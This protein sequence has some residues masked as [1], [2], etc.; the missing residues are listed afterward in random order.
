MVRV[1]RLEITQSS[2][3]A[4]RHADADGVASSEGMLILN[5]GAADE[6]LARTLLRERRLN[7]LTQLLSSAQDISDVLADIVR[8]AVELV[9]ADAGALP[10]LSDDGTRLE[11]HYTHG[12]PEVL[13]G[14]SILRGTGLAWQIID[15]S[16]PALLNDYQWLDGAL[17]ELVNQDVRAVIG[18]PIV[19]EERPVGV[20]ALYRIGRDDNFT[21]HDLD[22]L[23][24]VGR[25]VGMAIERARRYQAAVREA[26]RRVVLFT[27]SQQIGA[28][29]DLSQLYQLIH[30]AVAQ[31]VRCD[32]FTLTLID[33]ASGLP[34]LVYRS[35]DDPA[36]ATPSTD[37]LTS[38][39]LATG[40]SLCMTGGAQ[41]THLLIAMRRGGHTVGVMSAHV[42]V[43]HVYSGADLELLDQ[44][45]TTAAI[46]IENA[47]LFE[48]ARREATVRTHLYHA[49]QRLGALL[50][51]GQLYEELHRAT[52]SLV[53]CDGFL[54]ALQSGEYGPP[55]VVYRLGR[56]HDDICD[57][58][59][60]RAI[61]SGESLRCEGEP[62]AGSAL[63]A[64][65]R[66]G[67]RVVGAILV[68]A[69]ALHAYTDADRSAIELLAATAAIAIENAR[70]FADARRLATID[71]LTG[72]WS[73]RSFFEHATRE[74]Q[75]SN[76]TLRPLA[77]LMVDADDFKV[78]ND[79]YGHAAGDQVLRGLAERCCSLLRTIDV[80]GRY[81]GEEFAVVLPETGIDSAINVAERLRAAV[82]GT[83]FLTD[84]GALTL[85]VSVGVTVHVPGDETTFDALL[86]RADRAMYVAKQSGRNRV[87]TWS[88][89]S[90]A[91]TEPRD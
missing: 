91:R 48:A 55:S 26:E 41:H 38:Q 82:A 35:T 27:A 29:L 46:A 69:R 3:D 53:V 86:D 14:L 58:L 15:S 30:H 18:V 89:S 68:R 75:R 88:D 66:R 83:P 4:A 28:S 84:R 11:F 19:A 2:A 51:L 74:F 40:Q 6:A 47:R 90:L 49:S 61:A 16:L 79:T 65:M 77:I 34:A 59:V 36:I 43:P 23:A 78:V 44:L 5:N 76:R 72:V 50:E 13:Q 39:V 60:S 21:P 62:C 12:I 85:T 24:I 54:V 20:L 32:A 1:R 45:A 25:Q 7:T 42:R 57:T 63:V 81:G 10:L 33:N 52:A 70:L 9:E 37:E 17:V 73:R 64:L 8:M 80:V 31:L 56:A 67:G 87:C 71:E 22:L